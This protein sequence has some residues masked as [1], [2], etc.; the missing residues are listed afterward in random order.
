MAVNDAIGSAPTNTWTD[1]TAGMTGSNQMTLYSPAWENAQ[2]NIANYAAGMPQW[3]NDVYQNWYSGDLTATPTQGYQQAIQ[4]LYQSNP[5][6]DY[7]TDNAMGAAGRATGAYDQMASG[8][9]QAQGVA[10]GGLGNINKAGSTLDMA[11][12]Y[13]QQ[14]AQMLGA[15]PQY[16]ASELQKY[17]NPYTQQAAQATVS[18]LNRNLTENLMPGVNSTFTGAGQFGS[19]RNQ[20]FAN[21]AYRDTQE[22]AAKA[23]AQANYGAFNQA[24]QTYS[25]WANKGIQAGTAMGN[26]A[27]QIANVGQGYTQAGQAQG[28]LGANLGNIAGQ[29]G[30]LG[31][32]WLNQAKTYG[33]LA[34]AASNLRQTDLTNA[35]TAGQKE[36]DLSQAALD[37]QYQDWMK[38]QQFP[39]TALGGLGQFAGQAAAGQ[40][41]TVF[42]E[43]AKPDDLTRALS[44]MSILQ[45][46][47]GSG[48]VL[49]ADTISGLLG[50]V[51]DAG[52]DVYK[53]LT[54]AV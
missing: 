33:D 36:Y 8:L 27:S 45:S 47:L 50:S 34:G 12:P 22:A 14:S 16:S 41:K 52:G 23:L 17:L 26:L 7:I 11:M 40:P 25:D 51:Y 18:D 15:A 42:S 3:A 10:I 39:L 19:T 48:E 49:G 20:D 44:A 5:Y 28:N 37:A 35:M 6:T 54:G 1:P 13:V 43:Q 24:N 32:D 29:Y 9:G 30:T 53:Q 46:G 2:T 38:R 21:R 4:N 31:N